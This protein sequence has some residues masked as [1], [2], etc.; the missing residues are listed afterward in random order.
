MAVRDLVKMI[1]METNYFLAIYGIH[2]CDFLLFFSL[3]IQTRL[4]VR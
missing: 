4:P 3:S 1:H 2:R